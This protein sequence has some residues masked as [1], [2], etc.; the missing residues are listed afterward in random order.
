[1][2]FDPE[3]LDTTSVVLISCFELIY[4]G[5]VISHVWHLFIDNKLSVVLSKLET[6]HET[7]IQLNVVRPMKVKMN[8]FFIIGIILNCIG[9]NIH[10]VVT[11]I[12]NYFQVVQSLLTPVIINII[13]Y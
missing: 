13:Q 5:Q 3:M 6:I 1:L 7:L 11:I 12:R 2:R 4:I 8:W 10:L 9:F